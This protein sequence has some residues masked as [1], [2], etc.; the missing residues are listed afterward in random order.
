MKQTHKNI[1]KS[2]IRALCANQKIIIIYILSDAIVCTALHRIEKT[3]KFIHG[4]R[5]QNK[6][7]K[8]KI[9]IV[10]K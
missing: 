6:Q 7:I 8:K 2:C 5:Q 10:R 9:Q 4:Q 1:R 3:R